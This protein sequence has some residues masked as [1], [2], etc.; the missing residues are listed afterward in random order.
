MPRVS[1]G[2]TMRQPKPS[3]RRRAL[4]T[5]QAAVILSFVVLLHAP[6]VVILSPWIARSMW[7]EWRGRRR[8]R[9]EGRLLTLPAA[10]Q[11]LESDGGILLVALGPKGLGGGC[12]VPSDAVGADCPL[13]AIDLGPDG[14]WRAR[15]VCRQPPVRM[16]CESRLLGLA[17]R[18]SLVPRPKGGWERCTDPIVHKARV[19]NYELWPDPITEH[20]AATHD[21]DGDDLPLRGGP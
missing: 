1:R 15:E 6:F 7:D 17:D 5:G 18:V 12:W 8:L 10:R 13:P 3:T 20:S 21:M 9:R 4:R 14:F 2:F 16:W 11:R 19:V